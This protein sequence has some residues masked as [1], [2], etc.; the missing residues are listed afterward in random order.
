VEIAAAKQL[1]RDLGD[2]K[3]IEESARDR[4]LEKLSPSNPPAN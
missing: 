3:L 2:A 4:I 1:A